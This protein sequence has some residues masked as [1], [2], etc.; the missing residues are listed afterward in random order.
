MILLTDK[1][2]KAY[3]SLECC[4]IC[5]KKIKEDNADNKNYNEVRDHCHYTDKYRGVAYSMCNIKFVNLK[6]PPIVFS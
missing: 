5:C 4:L 1:E 2:C 6:K 3:V